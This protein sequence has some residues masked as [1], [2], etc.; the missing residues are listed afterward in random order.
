MELLDLLKNG[1]RKEIGEAI[2]VSELLLENPLLVDHLFKLLIKN[3]NDSTVISHGTYALK[4]AALKNKKICC[5]SI[6]F[7]IDNIDNFNQWEA[8][9]N[10]LRSFLAFDLQLEL[11]NSSEPIIKKLL[12]DKSAIVVS[13]ALEALIV[14]N[15]NKNHELKSEILTF[16]LEHPKASVRARARK[17]IKKYKVDY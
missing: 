14:L 7:Y 13:Y 4:E 5:K 9:E 15:L 2:E 1:D 10:F 6:K 17:I 8:K 12:Y 3:K 11:L 16:G